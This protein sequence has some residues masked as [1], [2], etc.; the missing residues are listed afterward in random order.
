MAENTNGKENFNDYKQDLKVF[1]DLFSMSDEE[2]KKELDIATEL[3]EN[4]D[5]KNPEIRELEAYFAEMDKKEVISGIERVQRAEKEKRYNEI[6][7]SP[8]YQAQKARTEKAVQSELFVNEFERYTTFL[9]VKEPLKVAEEVIKEARSE[10]ANKL[11]VARVPLNEAKARDRKAKAKIDEKLSELDKYFEEYIKKPYLSEQDRI[12]YEEKKEL[13]KELLEKKANFPSKEFLEAKANVGKILN[14]SEESKKIINAKNQIKFMT[15]RNNW[16]QIRLMSKEELIDRINIKETNETEKV[17]PTTPEQVPAQET[18]EEQSQE[19][20]EA[21]ADGDGKQEQAEG[22]DKKGTPVKT[23]VTARTGEAPVASGVSQKSNE[24]LKEDN[25]EKIDDP[26]KDKSLEEDDDLQII[27]LNEEKRS[28]WARIKGLFTK[29][30]TKNK[31]KTKVRKPKHPKMTREIRKEKQAKMLKKYMENY[32]KLYNREPSFYERLMAKHAPNFFAQVR[33]V[34]EYKEPINPEDYKGTQAEELVAKVDEKGQKLEKV[35]GEIVYE[36]EQESRNYEGT[37]AQ[38]LAEKVAASKRLGE[39]SWDRTFGY[40]KQMDNVGQML[41]NESNLQTI[42]EYYQQKS[43]P[44]VRVD[45]DYRD[46]FSDE[47]KKVEAV[48]R[49]NTDYKDQNATIE[50]LRALRERELA[51]AG[52]E[53]TPKVVTKKEEMAEWKGGLSVRTP[54]DMK[55]PGIATFG[56]VLDSK[57]EPKLDLGNIMDRVNEAGKAK[58]AEARG[59]TVKPTSPEHGNGDR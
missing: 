16:G 8:E 14:D 4:R 21:K 23:T 44:V 1:K 27:D 49:V 57:K 20:A 47:P 43:N 2:L 33:N 26:N 41:D 7:S 24:E 58:A 19:V 40:I 25:S 22:K 48:M 13:Q 55:K 12:E 31:E 56:K 3:F 50:D 52:K 45:T 28:I 29:S 17:E 34:I 54:Q 5:G 59:E 38:E 11:K 36:N 35:K 32:N 18:E 46:D 6:I 30:S 10:R 51:K 9:K 42:D 37:Q 53:D 15:D 39:N